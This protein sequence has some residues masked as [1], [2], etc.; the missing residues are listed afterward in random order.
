MEM[1]DIPEL[2]VHLESFL[3][4]I[5]SGKQSCTSNKK[6]PFQVIRFEHRP[7]PL[8]ITQTT[9]GLSNYLLEL[10]NGSTIRQELCLCYDS[11]SQD[12]EPEIFLFVIG[13][14]VQQSK[15]AVLR[16]SVL[17]PFGSLFPSSP[18]EAFY[19]TF[20][21]YFTEEFHEFNQVE[22]QVVFVWLLPIYLEEVNF[23]SEN[24]WESFE[25]LLYQTEIDL[26]DY[27]RPS[28]VF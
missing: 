12:L 10:P 18:L 7:S 14:D 11:K 4:P 20:P 24:G 23:I 16:G 2:V 27:D 28:I 21:L 8:H 1:Q 6:L 3:G 26:L 13:K 5:K 22:P 19:C 9:L 15:K 17:G 25:E